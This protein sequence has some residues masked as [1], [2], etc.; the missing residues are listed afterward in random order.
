MRP[1]DESPPEPD[2][3]NSSATDVYESADAEELDRAMREAI[4]ENA[5]APGLTDDQAEELAAGDY[6]SPASVELGWDSA[7]LEFRLAKNTA[8]GAA[9]E[10]FS[11]TIRNPFVD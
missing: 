10:K 1:G 2:W 8:I 3:Y 9:P 7:S 11:V 6:Y 5:Y 4:I